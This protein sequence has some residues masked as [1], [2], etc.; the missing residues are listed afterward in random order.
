MFTRLFRAIF[1]K[2]SKCQLPAW[3]VTQGLSLKD[4]GPS[5]GAMA[6]NFFSNNSPKIFRGEVRAFDV[7]GSNWLGWWTLGTIRDYLDY[8]GVPNTF[9]TNTALPDKNEVG[10][11]H[12][13]G[14]HFVVVQ[15]HAVGIVKIINPEKFFG[16]TMHTDAAFKKRITYAYN[17]RVK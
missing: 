17:I 16:C 13:D 6:Y 2:G 5:C 12:V 11:Y 4:C 1:L 9:S 14:N 15:R 7:S 10:I 3:Y 8:K